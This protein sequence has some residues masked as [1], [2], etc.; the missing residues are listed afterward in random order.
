MQAFPLKR[1]IAGD[2]TLVRVTASLQFSGSLAA[3]KA[4]GAPIEVGVGQG[5]GT[6]PPWLP[7]RWLWRA[8]SQG[9][10]QPFLT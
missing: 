5:G 8:E 4:A 6:A 1:S 7:I 10:Y 9:R 2:T 3:P